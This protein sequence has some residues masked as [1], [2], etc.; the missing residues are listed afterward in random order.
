MSDHPNVPEPKKPSPYGR[1]GSDSEAADGP[2]A[3][4]QADAMGATVIAYL[5]TGPA[6][7]GGIGWLLA[8]WLEARIFIPIGIVIGMALSLYTIWLR[9]GRT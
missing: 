4:F 9:Y 3:T 5:I 2:S 1:H 7:F 8:Q 6:L